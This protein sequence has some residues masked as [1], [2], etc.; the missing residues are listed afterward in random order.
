M[1][2]PPLPRPTRRKDVE[3]SDLQQQITAKVERL[4]VLATDTSFTFFWNNLTAR[5][6]NQGHLLPGDGKG[7]LILPP[8]GSQHE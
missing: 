4:A 5:L 3:I 6:R 2:R 8:K 7:G 1:S